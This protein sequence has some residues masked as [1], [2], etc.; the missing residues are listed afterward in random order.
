[1]S[2]ESDRRYPIDKSRYYQSVGKLLPHRIGQILQELGFGSW[3]AQ[4]QSNDVDLK[5]FDDEGNLII[6]AEILNWS[7]RSE[8]SENRKNRI[9]KNLL[10]YNCKR[11]LIYTTL[12]NE[13]VLDTFATY[14]ISLLKIGF[15]LLPKYFYDFC[16]NKNQI[17]YRKTDSRETIDNLDRR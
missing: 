12:E 6:V 13:Q 2:R 17:E 7:S 10:H 3:I 16:A 14:G 8:L 15:Q 5:V 9:I 11:L 1:M 4:G